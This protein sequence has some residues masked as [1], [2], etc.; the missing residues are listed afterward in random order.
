MDKMDRMDT[1]SLWAVTANSYEKGKFLEGNEEADVVIIGSGITGT[2]VAYNALSRE[3]ALN[4]VMLEAREV[5]SGATGRSVPKSDHLTSHIHSFHT[6]GTGAISTLRFITTST[7]SKS[8]T[9]TARQ[10]P[11]S[12]SVVLTSQRCWK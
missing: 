4:V 12:P 5:C 6:S 2:S 10:G 11:S 9:E 7:K 8:C 1:L 3:S